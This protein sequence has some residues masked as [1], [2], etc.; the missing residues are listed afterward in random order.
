MSRITGDN[1]Y[2]ELADT[3]AE[4]DRWLQ[5]S[6]SEQP[7]VEEVRQNVVDALR[8]RIRELEQTANPKEQP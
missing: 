2:D 8:A 4:L 1:V 3:S 5:L 7:A 6:R